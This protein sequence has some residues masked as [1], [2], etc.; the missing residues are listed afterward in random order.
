MLSSS[1]VPGWLA[2]VGSTLVA[3]IF[4]AG[5]VALLLTNHPV[6]D[7]LWVL[8]GVIATAYFGSGPFWGA[9]GHATQ[10][11]NSLLGT[12]AR[13]IDG[14]HDVVV[15]LGQV[16]AAMAAMSGTGTSPTTGSGTAGTDRPAPA[17]GASTP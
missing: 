12:V 14:L 4:A 15:V 7:Q 16:S 8:S 9:L 10:T 5:L 11:S 2:F 3:V 13:S 6:P 17:P 1:S